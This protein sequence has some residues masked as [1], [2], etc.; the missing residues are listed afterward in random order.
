MAGER[1]LVTGAAGFVGRYLLPYLAVTHPDWTLTGTAHRATTDTALVPCDLADDAATVALVRQ[2]QP[3][4]VVHLA[5]Q[6]DVA[7]SFRDAAE[8]LSTNILGTLHLLQACRDYAPAARLLIV[9]SSEVYGKTPPEVQ[10]VGEAYPLA[11][12]SPY[13]VSKAA[14]EMLALQFAGSYALD[15]VI[16]RPFNHIGP[17]QTDRFAISSFARQIVAIERGRQA[18]LRVG[19]LDAARDFTDVRDIVRAY[20]LLLTRGRTKT[21]YNIGRGCAVTL[22]TA[23]EMLRG[24]AQTTIAVETDPAR[25]RPSDVPIMTADTW[26]LHEATGWKP[27]IALDISVRD[28]LTWWRAQP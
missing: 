11:P 1:V 3:A 5:G 27:E 28:M 17:A 19:N 14:V 26:R 12:A 13:A 16:A 8:T 15:V 23:V 20:D 2:T 4:F 22:H 24:M 10:P 6:S 21:A 9:S 25:L 18:A 7:Q